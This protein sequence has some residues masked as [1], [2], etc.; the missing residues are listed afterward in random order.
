MANSGQEVITMTLIPVIITVTLLSDDSV[1]EHTVAFLPA[2][3]KPVFYAGVVKAMT[4]L[5]W[6]LH[7]AA[8]KPARTTGRLGDPVEVVVKRAKK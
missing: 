2:G 8:G 5:L 7:K 4:T 1:V 6:G 3:R